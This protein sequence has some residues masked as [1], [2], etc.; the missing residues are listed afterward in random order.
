MHQLRFWLAFGSGANAELA[1]QGHAYLHSLVPW[2]VLLLGVAVG[3]FLWALGRALRRSALRAALRAVTAGALWLACTVVRWSR[4]TPAQELLE[5]LFA[6]GHPGG[7]AGVFG[8]GGWWSIPAAVCIGLVLAAVLHGARWVLDEVAR[9]S[10]GVLR[11]AARRP[12]GLLRPRDAVPAAALAAGW[13]L[14][15][16]RSSALRP[17]RAPPSA[18]HVL[19]VELPGCRVGSL[20]VSLRASLGGDVAASIAV[21]ERRAISSRRTWSPAGACALRRWWPVSRSSDRTGEP[22]RMKASNRWARRPAIV[23]GVL[24]LAG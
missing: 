11:G 1:R 3:A 17:D 8:Y 16:P 6:T 5:G 22:I 13:R 23:A 10:R 24:A 2:I 18:S 7:L 14:V 20:C 15:G 9:R 12:A 21:G 19:L 4:S